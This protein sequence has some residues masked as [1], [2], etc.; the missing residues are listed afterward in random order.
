[1]EKKITIVVETF[2][3]DESLLKSECYSYENAEMAL[4]SQQEFVEKRLAKQDNGEQ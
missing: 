1:M 2:I 3:D 4:S